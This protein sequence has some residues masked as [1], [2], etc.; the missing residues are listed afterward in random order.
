MSL[1]ELAPN[2]ACT[3]LRC[4]TS[5]NSVAQSI[6]PGPTLHFLP[7]AIR[8]LCYDGVADEHGGLAL[9][10]EETEWTLSRWWIRRS[11]SCASGVA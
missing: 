7:S 1:P 8:Q 3:P 10:R 4:Y 5:P 11:P 2:N 9:S 6:I